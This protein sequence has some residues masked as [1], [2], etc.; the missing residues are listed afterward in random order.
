MTTIASEEQ[1]EQELSKKGDRLV[2]VEFSAASPAL[3]I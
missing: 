3:C 1:W 2:I